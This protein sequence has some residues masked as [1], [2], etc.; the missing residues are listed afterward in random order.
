MSIVNVDVV[1][2]KPASV[3]N[4][5]EETRRQMTDEKCSDELETLLSVVRYAGL[6]EN[7]V[8]PELGVQ[9]GHIA[10]HLNEEVEAGVSLVE[11]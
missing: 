4:C 9:Q 7:G 6:E 8:E 11:V 1:S 3:V 2:G 5:D 10:I